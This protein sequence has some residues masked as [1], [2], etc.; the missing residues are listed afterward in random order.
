[1]TQEF[2]FTD[3]FLELR[4]MLREFCDECSGEQ[5][6]RE[7][8]DSAE[9]YDRQAWRRLGGE[10]GVLGLAVPSQLG[11]DD[12]GLVF[13]AGVVEELGAA[14]LC[15]PVLGTLA[16]AIPALCAIGDT[17]Q[18]ARLLPGLISG[19]LIATLAITAPRGQFDADRIT[20]TATG[21]GQSWSL[22]GTVAHV[23]DGT[24]ADTLLVPATTA[25]GVALFAVD[26]KAAGLAR[27]AL[28]TMDLTRRQATVTLQ[29]CPAQLI[30][31]VDEAPEVCR[32]ALRT[33][34]V[35]IG[36]EQVG[37]AQRMLDV[38][39]AHVSSRIQFGQPVGAFQAVKHRCANM[40]VALEQARSAVYHGAWALQDGTDDPQL[41]ASLARVAASEAY[42]S[43]SRAAIQLH[44]G[45]GFTWE[46]LP[47]LYFKR[48]S[49]D[50]VQLGS[51]EHHVDALASLVVDAADS[52]A[53]A[54]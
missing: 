29:D 26:G 24:V 25:E 23:P 39:V 13:T 31:G 20:V 34:C 16:L 12:A 15:G 38:T 36:A 33:A 52:L 37:G 53:V 22:T 5:R 4:G 32:T 50:A 3:D 27:T 8:M 28:S 1:V 18:A 30:A 21:D 7:I 51:V 2:E 48:A 45:L 14:L 17:E 46:G 6:V 41:A 40:L 19:E 35:L 44:G 47:H 43:I 10:L 9:G 54:R 11:G 42:L 49:T